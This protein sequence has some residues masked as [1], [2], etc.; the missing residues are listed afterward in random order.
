MPL[1]IR[2]Y[3]QSPP[4]DKIITNQVDSTITFHIKA[5]GF[6]LL[7]LNFMKPEELI[8]NVNNYTIHKSDGNRYYIST[9]PLKDD[10]AKLLDI[11]TSNIGFSKSTLSFYMENLYKKK[12]KVV[13]RLTLNFAEFYNLYKPYEVIPEKVEVF[14]P[15]EVL[16]TLEKVFTVPVVLND[17]KASM[18]VSIKIDN[19][20]KSFIRVNPDK[21]KVI[22]DVTRFTQSSVVIPVTNPDKNIQLQTFP[23]K[24]KIYYDVAL[25]DFDKINASD[26]TVVPEFDNV[27]LP[28]VE[29]LYLKIVK[30]PDF[31]RNVR[32]E[33]ARVEFIILK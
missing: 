6:F 23:S 9:Q 1:L 21:I 10:I 26:F 2:V 24:V 4:L 20:K 32:L 14:G 12:V 27:D 25:K 19:K 3:M 15:K 18:E 8:V 29:K 17:V 5:Q 22:L 31:V 33:P 7:K 30:K 16:D 28:K 13:P 11:S